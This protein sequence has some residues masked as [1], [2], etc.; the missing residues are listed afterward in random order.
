MTANEYVDAAMETNDYRSLDRLSESIRRFHGMSLVEIDIGSLLLGCLGLSGEVGE[1]NDLIK[2]WLFN[3]SE[4]DQEHVKKEIG[5]ILWYIACICDSFNWDLE[6]I[7]Q[8][9]LDKLKKRY[10]NG[11]TVKAANNRKEGDI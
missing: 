6:E 8:M 5:D 7:M 2:K 3:H 11:F 4:I 9:N 1:F 10:P